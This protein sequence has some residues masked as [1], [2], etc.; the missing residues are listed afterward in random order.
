MKNKYIVVAISKNNKMTMAA[1][2]RIYDS[3]EDAAKFLDNNYWL[4]KNKTYKISIIE[5][6]INKIFVPKT[7]LEVV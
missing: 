5:I 2:S 7:T 6:E 1:N 3:K 4:T